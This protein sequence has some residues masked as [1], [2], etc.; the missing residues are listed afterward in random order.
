MLK[1]LLLGAGLLIA[2]A[3]LGA[4][5]FANT[6]VELPKETDA[7]VAAALTADLP[8]LVTGKTGVATNGPIDIWY[9]SKM[10]KD[11]VKGTILLVMGLGASAMIWSN[12]FIQ[13][14]LEAGYQVIRYDN[15]DTGLSTWVEDWDE[16]DPYTLEDMAKDG[17]A[18][19]DALGIRKAHVVGASMGGMIAQRMAISHADRVASLTSIMSSGYVM[20]PD[21]EPVSEEL[22]QEYIKVG[23]KY[24]LNRSEENVVKFHISNQQLLKGDGPYMTNVKGSAQATLY[25]L[26]KRKGYSRSTV[27]QQM[28]A[29]TVSGSRLEELGKITVPTLILHGKAD[30]LVGFQ[31]AQKY[32]PLIPNAETL[33]IEGMGHDLPAIYWEQIHSG[34]LGIIGKAENLMKVSS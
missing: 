2:L 21:I 6:A 3:A 31:H 11:S 7:I 34:I 23:L 8:E 5:L 17:M 9:E 10:P 27:D 14:F 22:N 30:P 15:R 26:R 16:N 29:I 13:P 25:E 12:E 20:D 19:L 32:A 24:L 1:K 4:Y 18:V 28:K 33:F